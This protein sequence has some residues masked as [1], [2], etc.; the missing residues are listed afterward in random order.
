MPRESRSLQP[1]FCA[2]LFERCASSGQVLLGIGFTAL[3][4]QPLAKLAAGHGEPEGT[5]QPGGAVDCC[6]ELA[7]GFVTVIGRRCKPCFPAENV[8][9]NRRL[10]AGAEMVSHQLQQLV[11]LGKLAKQESGLDRL[12][13]RRSH[14]HWEG[15]SDAGTKCRLRREQRERV[16][17]LSVRDPGASGVMLSTHLQ[18]GVLDYRRARLDQLTRGGC[19]ATKD[20]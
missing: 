15:L 3:G 7:A 6:N 16:V 5:L 14:S 2:Q 4:N 18:L 10:A 19:V 8:S 13:E 11:D 1:R 20:V 17:T 9:V 12:D